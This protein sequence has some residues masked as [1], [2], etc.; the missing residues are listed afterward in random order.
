MGEPSIEIVFKEAGITAINRGAKGI[1]ALILKDT[2]P[3]SYS[4]PIKMETIEEIPETLSDFNKEQIKLAMIGYQNQPKQ[5]IAYIEKVD[6][7]DHTEA[8]SYLEQYLGID[9][10][11][12]LTSLLLK[13]M[14]L[15]P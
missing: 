3:T 2:M 6:A 10:R 11:K 1:V 4:N 12:T 14:A 5:I 9:D 13:I 7:T 8:Q 15:V